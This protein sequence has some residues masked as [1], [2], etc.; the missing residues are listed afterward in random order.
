MKPTL[1]NGD[2]IVVET[3]TK[4][5]VVEAV[6]ALYDLDGAKIVKRLKGVQ[7]S[8]YCCSCCSC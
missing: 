8:N 4:I 1:H 7:V 3:V 5:F 2:I 6:L